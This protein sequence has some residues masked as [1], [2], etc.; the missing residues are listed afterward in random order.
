MASQVFFGN[1]TKQTWIKAPN[2]GMKAGSAGFVSEQQLLSGRTFIK[3]SKASH[4]RFDMSWVGPMNDTD[5]DSSLHTV[6]DF[7]DGVYGPGPFFWI[8]PYATKTNLFSTA[9]ASPALAVDS[10]WDE[11]FASAAALTATTVT[12][13]A[14]TKEYPSL[15]AEYTYTGT[16][17]VESEKFTFYIPDG[18]SLWLGF[19]G[20]ISSSGGAYYVPYKDGVAD[21]AVKLTELSVTSA[22]RVNKQITSSVA[23]KV[24]FYF[25]KTGTSDCVFTLA[26]IMAQILKTGETPATGNF[27]A[28]RGTTGLEFATNPEIEYYSA[29]INNGQIGLSLTMAEV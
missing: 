5:L 19:H 6:K 28:G 11:L 23:D 17:T 16:A 20:S 18:Y 21:T 27:L 8:D 29:N 15:S 1:D 13:D 12:T 9:W 3:R 10:D 2:S 14:N 26:G 7:F 22:I 25:A 4:R 24:E